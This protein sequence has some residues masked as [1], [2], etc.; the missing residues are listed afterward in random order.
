MLNPKTQIPKPKSQLRP[1][2]NLELGIWDLGFA[3]ALACAP[4]R[5][6]LFEG[7]LDQPFVVLFRHVS[8]K[9]LRRDADREVHRFLADLLQRT[10][11]LEL[12]LPLGI[13]HHC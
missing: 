4:S 8:L 9:D 3:H 2:W 11:C 10:R 13:A 1:N 5:F 7:F 12:D 6:E